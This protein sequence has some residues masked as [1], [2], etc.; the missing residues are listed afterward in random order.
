MLISCRVVGRHVCD[1][2]DMVVGK[3]LRWWLYILIHDGCVI[4]GRFYCS[5]KRE[6]DREQ[7][8]CPVFFPKKSENIL[9]K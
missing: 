6:R 3:W 8:N 5:W 1:F 4:N 7:T 2:E 9:E